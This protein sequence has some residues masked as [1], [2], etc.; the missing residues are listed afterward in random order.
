MPRNCSACAHDAREAIDRELIGN[1]PLSAI[2][3]KYRDLTDDALGR[4]KAHHLP[5]PMVAAQQAADLAHGKDLLA[6]VESLRVRGM[7]LLDRAE[8][9]GKLAT[10]C[11]ALREVKGILELQGR[12]LLAARQTE[13]DIDLVLPQIAADLRVE[14]ATLLAEAER[15]A[16]GRRFGS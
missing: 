11:V 6:E 1:A 7:T 13:R 12:L 16:S 2:A 10:A 8:Q 3:A 5:L 14:P 9:E 15:I 4:H